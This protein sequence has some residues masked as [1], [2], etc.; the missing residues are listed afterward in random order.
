M[1]LVGHDCSNSSKAALKPCSADSPLV[2]VDSM[3]S[4]FKMDSHSSCVQVIPI[5]YQINGYAYGKAWTAWKQTRDLRWEERIGKALFIGTAKQ[6]LL[7]Q[8]V[9]LVHNKTWYH[10][11]EP[12]YN[13][14]VTPEHM[15]V[16]EAVTYRYLIDIGGSSGTTWDALQWKMA[17]GALVFKVKNPAGAVDFW[18]KEMTPGVHYWPWST[19]S[20]TCM[21]STPGQNRIPKRRRASPRTVRRSR[22]GGAALMRSASWRTCCERSSSSRIWTPGRGCQRSNTRREHERRPLFSRKS[23]PES[24]L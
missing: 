5:I 11:T 12:H 4:A 1:T 15:P 23:K 8:R 6:E 17:S 3:F 24:K 7:N 18:Q 13:W 20:A 21:H 19:T 10:G 16:E 9:H 22:G 14:L 2:L